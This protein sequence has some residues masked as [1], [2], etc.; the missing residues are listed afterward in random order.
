MLSSYQY[1]ITDP[2]NICIGNV[3]KLVSYVIGKERYALSGFR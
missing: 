1:K 2:F 3:K